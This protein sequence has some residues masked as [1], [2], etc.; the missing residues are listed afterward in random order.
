MI[1][2]LLLIVSLVTA[3]AFAVDKSDP[4]AKWEPAIAKFEAKDSEKMPPEGAVLFVGSSSIRG[5]DCT[6]WFPDRQTINRGF[7]GS[8]I[9]D[10]NAFVDRIVLKYKP[11]SIVF[12]AGDN[13]I[14]RGKSPETV[15]ADYKQFLDTVAKHL[16]DT[17]VVW[18]P[19]KPSIKRWNLWPTML[20][21]NNMVRDWCASNFHWHYADCAT[22]MLGESGE[23]MQDLFVADGLHLSAKGYQLWSGIVESHLKHVDRV[24]TMQSARGTVFHDANNNATLDDNET[25]LA[26]MRVSNGR[27]IVTTDKSGRYEIPVDDDDIVFVIK[28]SGWRTPISQD[29]LPRFYYI[30]KPN[31]SPDLVYGGVKPTGPLPAAIDFPLYPQDEPKEFQAIIFADPQPRTQQQVDYVAHDVVRELVGTKASLGVTLGDIL[32]DDL[33]LFEPQNKAIALIGIPWYNV[34]GN[35]DINFDAT[36]DE[37]SDETFERVFGPAYYSFDHGTVHFLVLDNVDWHIE[38]EG[39]RGRYRAGMSE[40]QLRFIRNDL[41]LVPQEKLV[42]LM[43]HI[44]L[45]QLVQKS[46]LFRLIEKRPYTMSMSG[47]THYHAHRFLKKADGWRGAE[48]HHHLI[49]VTVSGCW[50]RGAKDERGIPIATMQDGAP[51]G[52]SIITFNGSDYRVDYKAASK[53]ADYQMN[54]MVP[55]EIPENRI[56][57]T[58]VDVNVFNG[59]EFSKVEMSI[60]GK[61]WITL[62][63]T[64]DIDKFFQATVDIERQLKDIP[65][66]PLPGPRGSDHLWRGTLPVTTP[67]G[68]YL[69]SVKVTDRH[70]RTLRDQRVVRI[71]KPVQPEPVKEPEAKSEPADT[72]K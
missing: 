60:D 72:G 12:Y 35:H 36:S 53:P 63:H 23:P 28:P 13:D 55:D 6:K 40:D 21:A 52:Y 27:D 29:M 51:N 62:K 43:M 22:P 39:K 69:I 41:A 67:Q 49:N 50:W 14:G 16:P 4:A 25:T 64:R 46:E 58:P 30:H 31:G 32:F 34:I 70:G 42:V 10:V 11:K 38:E 9:S 71:G 59:S 5:W 33:S 57:Q 17:H 66:T 65:W 18:V 1:T 54:I 15:L 47:H 26:N 37:M 56:E 3:S 7:G 68:V 48:P 19:I 8:M 2:R 20:T 61:H 45:T 44:P 24:R